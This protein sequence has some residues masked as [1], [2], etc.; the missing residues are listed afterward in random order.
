MFRFGSSKNAYDLG[1]Y[2]LAKLLTIYSPPHATKIGEIENIT[3]H[4]QRRIIV[5]EKAVTAVC[6]NIDE[7]L[8]IM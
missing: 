3:P 4:A 1:L 7:L 5:G 6:E 8:A 2:I